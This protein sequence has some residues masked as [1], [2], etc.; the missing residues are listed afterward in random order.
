[1][2]KVE[3]VTALSRARTKA[4]SQKNIISG[5]RSAAIHPFNPSKFLLLH[6]QTSSSPVAAS[7]DNMTPSRTTPLGTIADENRA[8]IQDNPALRTPVKQR[9]HATSTALE[10]AQTENWLLRQELSALRSSMTAQKRPRGGISVRN[11]GTHVFS[12]ETV[13]RIVQEKEDAIRARKQG[14]KRQRGMSSSPDPL[15]EDVFM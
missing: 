4:M 7:I 14:L 5:F 12:T 9:L 2:Q 6:S 11:L 15:G 10:T 8:F 3:W 13:F 1:M